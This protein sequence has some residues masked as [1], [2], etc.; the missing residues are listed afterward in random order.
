VITG[1]ELQVVCIGAAIAGVVGC[2]LTLVSWPDPYAQIGHAGEW[3]L[4]VHDGP[5]PPLESPAGR[6]EVLQLEAA[7]AALRA[8]RERR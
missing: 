1:A 2:L 4:D 3:S 5:S 6:A 7:L 8:R